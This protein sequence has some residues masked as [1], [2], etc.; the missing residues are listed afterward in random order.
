MSL[1]ALPT[2]LLNLL[3]G[4]IGGL[5]LLSLGYAVPMILSLLFQVWLMTAMMAEERR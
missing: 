5:W 1:L 2:M 4:I 3:A